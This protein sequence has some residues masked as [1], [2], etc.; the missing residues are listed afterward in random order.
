MPSPCPI[1]R[2]ERRSNQNLVECVTCKNFIHHGNRFNCSNLTDTEF[3]NHVENPSLF[4][5]CDNCISKSVLKNFALLPHFEPLTISELENSF[6]SKN[7]FF[8][9]V[10]AKHCDFIDKCSNTENFLNIENCIDDN[11]LNAV[12][13]NYYSLKDYNSLK[14]NGQSC[15]NIGHINIASLECH[16]DDLRFVSSKLKHKFHLL[17]ITE[18]KIKN[19]PSSNIDLI[20][21]EKFAF[22][23][24]EG[25][26]GGRQVSM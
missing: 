22:S 18:H 2:K 15:F 20:G 9:S 7:N 1:C 23:P 12:N 11:V 26:H 10:K 24:T 8:T 16:I 5:Q 3:Q 25:T 21:Y 13:S 4:Y 6:G 17:G 19:T 14:P